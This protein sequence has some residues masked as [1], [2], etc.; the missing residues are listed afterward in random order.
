MAR[1]SYETETRE[2]AYR[3]WRDCGQ[4]IEETLAVLKKNG[5]FI[6]KRTIYHWMEK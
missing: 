4:N 5:Y 2:D 6:S 3:T 1:R